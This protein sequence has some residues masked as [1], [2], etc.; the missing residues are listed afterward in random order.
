MRVLAPW[1]L[2]MAAVLLSNAT[3][4]QQPGELYWRQAT[5]LP[6]NCDPDVNAPP[7][8]PHVLQPGEAIILG[9]V[10]APMA[11]RALLAGYRP[12]SAKVR[13]SAC[14]PDLSQPK[15]AV[16]PPEATTGL[17]AGAVLCRAETDLPRLAAWRRNKTGGRTEGCR[18]IRAETPVRVLERAGPGRTRIR[19]TDQPGAEGWTDAWLPTRASR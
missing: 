4:A 2:T 18:I 17:A 1:W 3:M 16:S 10:A 13:D 12:R 9:A 7:R 11:A 19:T 15:S 5:P 8:N 6:G 14:R